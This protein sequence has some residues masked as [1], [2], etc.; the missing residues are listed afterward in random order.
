MINKLTRK[1]FWVSARFCFWWFSSEF[2]FFVTKMLF[3]FDFIT[4]ECVQT[5]SLGTLQI[6]PFILIENHFNYKLHKSG[7]KFCYYQ[8]YK[9]IFTI[10]TFNICNCSRFPSE[11]YTYYAF[12]WYMMVVFIF[13]CARSFLF[14]NISL[15]VNKTAAD[16]TRVIKPELIIFTRSRTLIYH[17]CGI[18]ISLRL[19]FGR[20]KKSFMFQ[21]EQRRFSTIIIGVFWPA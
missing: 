8:N 3:I 9:K 6:Q 18:R 13:E 16:G 20:N 17:Q 21:C 12:Q 10:T 14:G 19:L 5:K 4:A 1:V 2:V 7:I 11:L 15:K